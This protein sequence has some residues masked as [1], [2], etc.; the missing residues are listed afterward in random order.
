MRP[1]RIF[2]AG[3]LGVAGLAGLLTTVVPAGVGVAGATSKAPKITG[4]TAVPSPVTSGGGTVVTATV[5]NATSCTLSS[6]PAALSGTG[7]VACSGGTV[8]QAVA[9]AVN[10]TAKPEKYKLTLTAVGASVSRSKS[11]TV[12]V[13]PGAGTPPNITGANITG[14]TFLG[15]SSAPTISVTGSGFG[16][17]PLTGYSDA[18]NS[19][20]AYTNNG[21]T[22]GTNLYLQS[23]TFVAGLGAPPAMSCVGLIIASWTDTQITLTY[24][25]A[26]DT[27]G[28]WVLNSGDAYAMH[29]GSSVLTGTVVFS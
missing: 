17:A 8:S 20:G 9:F 10:S 28:P 25:N 1:S 23:T 12:K 22:F 27:F 16:P 4:L 15:N 5:A 21:S 6:A 13:N 11:V 14:V 19:C 3:T 18:S 26:Y 2:L 24:G 7:A 29:V